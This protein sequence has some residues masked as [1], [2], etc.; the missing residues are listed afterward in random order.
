MMR[1][2]ARGPGELLQ[3]PLVGDRQLSPSFG[4]APGNDLPP[5]LGTHSRTKSMLIGA[6]SSRWLIRPFHACQSFITAPMES[7]SKKR[8]KVKRILASCKIHRFNS[9]NC[10]FTSILEAV[11][12]PDHV[13]IDTLE[14]SY[15]GFRLGRTGLFGRPL[16]VVV[17]PLGMTLLFHFISIPMIEERMLTRRKNYHQVI[18]RVPR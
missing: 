14:P 16:L 17:G 2:P 4:P 1:T 18:A 8:D 9:S 15:P 12:L 11:K 10:L 13:A 7:F 3:P 6:S 5:V